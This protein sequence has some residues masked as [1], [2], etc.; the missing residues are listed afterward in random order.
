MLKDLYQVIVQTDD[1]ALQMINQIFDRIQLAN[2]VERGDVYV[3]TNAQHNR[4]IGTLP[5][6]GEM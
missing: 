3:D 4:M 6:E 5:A 2:K 1:V